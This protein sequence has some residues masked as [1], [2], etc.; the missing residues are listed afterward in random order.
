MLAHSLNHVGNWRANTGAAEESL[1]AHHEALDIYQAR[2]DKAGVAETL[3]LLGMANGIYGDVPRAVEHYKQA[4]DLFRELGDT[5]GLASSLSACWTYASPFVDE[6][7]YSALGTVDVLERAIPEALNLARQA[8]WA[9]GQAFVQF[10]AGS[11][12]AAFGELGRGLA[13]AQEALRIAT[14]IEHR[15]WI[16]GAHTHLGQ[17]YVFMLQP[18]PAIRALEAGRP[19]ARELGSAWWI[20]YNTTYLALA[21]LQQHDIPRAEAV[22]DETMPRD[23]APRNLPERRM[24]WAWGEVSLAKAQPD[25]ALSIADQLIE[26]APGSNRA[27][28]VPALLKL[29]GEALTAMSRLEEA[30]QSLEDAR[31][32]AQARGARPLLW[33]VH[34]SLGRLHQRL[35]DKEQARGEFETAR[36]IMRSL[37]ATIGDASLRESFAQAA[38]K[39]LPKETAL[40]PRQTI[41]REF[42]GLTEREREVAA[43]IAQG[44]A[45]RQI[46]D[47]LVVSERT[48]ET[49]VGNI[50]SKLGFASRAQIAAWAVEKGLA[51]HSE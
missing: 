33:Q 19:L 35:K 40:T 2:G 4:I 42:A 5:L 20:G 18:V 15:Q 16:G 11:G 1:K 30:R 8:E 17:I 41:K 13:C 46:A 14:E 38:L 32:G 10:M 43:L 39:T 22:L 45:N 7:T 6:T 31:R 44:K 25:V 26:S 21:Y 9:A 36:E 50:L 27:Q 51:H 24:A 37:A 34:R 28:P 3:D 23:R 48:V 12:F 47:D 29:K 49:H